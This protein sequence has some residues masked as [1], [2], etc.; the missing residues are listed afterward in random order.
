MTGLQVLRVAAWKS[1]RGLGD[2][3]LN[4][5]EAF[6]GVSSKAMKE[7]QSWNGR[8][9]LGRM[10]HKDWD[11]WRDVA[12]T[13]IGSKA[14]ATGL[15]GLKGVGYP[16]ATAILCILNPEVWPVMDKWAV[17]TVFGTRVGGRQWSTGRWQ[18]AKA[19]SAFAHHLATQGSKTWP[20]ER[21]IH[22][23][24]QLAMRASMPARG[25]RSAGT[26]PQGWHYATLP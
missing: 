5:E 11:D 18:K 8:S 14:K 6:R 20:A 19:Y 26:V 9:V 21:T 23:L 2:L 15:L 4:S 13:A 17:Q 1:G 10:S 7:I 24:D 3:T 25:K 16:M 12:A 22:S